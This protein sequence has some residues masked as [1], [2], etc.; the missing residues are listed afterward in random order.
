MSTQDET[1]GFIDLVGV[2]IPDI[3]A[4]VPDG[5]LRWM[6]QSGQQSGHRQPLG[7]RDTD[8]GPFF[9]RRKVHVEFQRRWPW[10]WQ[11]PYMG[12][13]KCQSLWRAGGRQLDKLSGRSLILGERE[14]M[15][16]F[17][18]GS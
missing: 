10:R 17:G 9:T 4:I 12:D 15:M 16:D 7:F 3:D 14:N 13:G 11:A 1:A 6:I 8:D 18:Q 5:S 2:E